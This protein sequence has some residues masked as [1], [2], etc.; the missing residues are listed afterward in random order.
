MKIHSL[1]IENTKRVRAVELTPQPNGLTVIGGN[2]GQGKTSV[3]DAIA[4]ALGG[5]KYRPSNAHR[6]GSVLPPMIRVTFD[7]GI[8][9]ERKGKNSALTV[10]DSTGRKAGQ[11]LLNEFICELAIDLPKFMNAS[12][13]E[14]AQT[15]L[16]IIGVGEELKKLDSEETELY[17]Q[18]RA[19]GRIVDQKRAFI[20][21]LPYYPD[22]PRDLVSPMDLI[23]RQQEILARNGENERKRRERDRLLEERHRVAE[24]LNALTQK[25]EQLCD[26]CTIAEKSAQD[27][28]DES[29]AEL[30]A[31]IATV[32]ETNRKVRANL[33]KDKAEEDGRA[34]S[35]Q[36]NEMTA[37]IDAIR[38]KRQALLDSAKLPLPGL[39]VEDGCL[40]YDGKRWDCMSSSQQLK[41]ATSIVSRLKPHCGFVLL[42]KLEQMDVQTMQE[43]GTWLAE[44]GLQAIATRVSGG[45]ECTIIIEDGMVAAEHAPATPEETPVKSWKKGGFA[46][47]NHQR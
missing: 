40:T 35:R 1:S 30:E 21:S 22:A 25:Y 37:Q 32:E 36:Y 28:Q 27:L 3:L 41:A 6:D 47:A 43:F 14:K 12:D 45:E 17:N 38:K 33:D 16:A 4:W 15:L 8:V 31:S 7:S 26:A 2:N 46:H 13:K 42:D 23:R 29:T 9:V 18:R 10:T 34:C 24:Q 44:N 20:E 5:E 11:Q 19:L 39:S